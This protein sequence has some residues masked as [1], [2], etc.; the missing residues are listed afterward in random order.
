MFYNLIKK[1]IFKIFYVKKIV[2]FVSYFFFSSTQLSI[3][4]VKSLIIF[5][6][7]LV[8]IF[9]QPIGKPPD[10]PVH[11]SA[12]DFY[13]KLILTKQ[14]ITI[15]FSWIRPPLRLCALRFASRPT[16]LFKTCWPITPSW[17][18]GNT[19]LVQRSTSVPAFRFK[20]LLWVLY[21][22]LFLTSRKRHFK[23][24]TIIAHT[25]EVLH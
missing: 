16:R 8:I 14:I 4:L 12:S 21:F 19:N 1:I 10:N 17:G 9:K 3:L 6:R 20:A 5:K 11:Q 7:S 2:L 25:Y 18:R 23:H 24:F 13:N 15:H 22:K